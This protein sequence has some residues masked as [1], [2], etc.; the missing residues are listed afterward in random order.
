MPTAVPAAISYEI[1]A[2][3]NLM[4]IGTVWSSFLVPIAIAL[5]FFSNSRMR[6]QPI[7][8]LNTLAIALGLALGGINIYNLVST[9][10]EVLGDELR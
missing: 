10:V 5:F 3:V 9:T 1:E 2:A 8:I 4:L 6:R 7:F